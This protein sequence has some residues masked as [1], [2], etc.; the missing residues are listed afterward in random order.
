MTRSVREIMSR[1]PVLVHVD[2]SLAEAAQRMKEEWN[3]GQIPSPHRSP[4]R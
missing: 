4:T 1:D 2:H 3:K